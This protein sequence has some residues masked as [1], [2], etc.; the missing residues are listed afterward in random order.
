M[1]GHG[2]KSGRK[3]EAAFAALL[4]PRNL[5]EAARAIDVVPNT[6]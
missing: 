6:L 5:E 4:T 2:T 3:K 1:K